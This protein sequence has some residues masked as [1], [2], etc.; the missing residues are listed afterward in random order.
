[1]HLY[2]GVLWN[3]HSSQGGRQK[4]KSMW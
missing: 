3:H 4:E 2:N 1:M